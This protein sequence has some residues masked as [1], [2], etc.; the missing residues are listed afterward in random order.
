M[1]SYTL[2]ELLY[3]FYDRIERRVAEEERTNSEADKIE[4][5]KEKG[6]LDWAEEEEKRELERE[7]RE[8]A[9]KADD[10]EPEDPTKDPENVAWMEEQLKKGKETFGDSFGEDIEENFE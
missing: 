1:Q 6:I 3:E 2:E 4:E 10:E 5:D 7:M 8:A 9:A